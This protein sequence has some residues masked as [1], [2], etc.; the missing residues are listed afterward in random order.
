VGGRSIDSLM[1]EI[2]SL[3]ASLYDANT[4]L[5]SY[6]T[7]FEQLKLMCQNQFLGVIYLGLSDQERAE[8]VLGFERYEDI[9]KRVAA[10][11]EAFNHAFYEGSLLVT[12]TGVH[13]DS[14]CVF[15][16]YERLARSPLHR[17]ETIARDLYKSLRNDLAPEAARGVA[18]HVG[19]SVLHYN[20]FLR[21]E[22]AVHHAAEDAVGVAGRQEEM[23]RILNELELRQ[24]IARRGLRTVFQPIVALDSLEAIG[25]EA[26]TRGP[27]ETPY[28]SPE[29]LFS[30]AQQ[31]K[32]GR[33]LDRL[34]K[35]TAIT[36]AKERPSGTYLFI[37]TLPTTLD[38]P[39]F[40]NGRAFE[41]LSA[42][43]LKPHD[44]VWELTER[45]PIEDF[46]AFG[47]IMQEFTTLG[48][49]IAI[50]DVGTGYSSIQTITH[51][52]PLYLKVDISLV[53]RIEENLL[54]QELVSSLLSLASNIHADL[55]AE[56]VET[57][58]E[59]NALKDLGVK[60]GQGY[61][62]G[63]PSE[64]FPGRVALQAQ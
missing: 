49:K 20:P 50:D 15:V 53:T 60:F 14:F 10:S 59:I 4:G 2:V 33:E 44:V 23:E 37:N 42:S 63:R 31:S 25:Y 8:A 43:N 45:N 61:I 64:T 34:C 51:V 40:L 55:I 56:G 62:F 41:N 32:L 6:A 1:N 29:A 19:Y 47:V 48:Y 46:D 22:R 21:F 7:K 18:P 52:R 39:E 9:L 36:S 5:P 57:Q 12:Q 26:L 17:L 13:G 24:I 54:K 11:L 27:V 58:A 38:D 30:C 35:L 28:E 16:P 3:R